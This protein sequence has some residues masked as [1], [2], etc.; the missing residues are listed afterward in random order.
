MFRARGARDI[1]W[2]KSGGLRSH[3]NT[4]LFHLQLQCVGPVPAI[5]EPR[6]PFVITDPSSVYLLN[7]TEPT[8]LTEY[9]QFEANRNRR[10]SSKDRFHRDSSRP[11]RRPC[12]IGSTSGAICCRLG[13]STPPISFLNGMCLCDLHS[14]IQVGFNGTGLLVTMAPGRLRRICCT[15]SSV[16]PSDLKSWRSQIVGRLLPWQIQEPAWGSAMPMYCV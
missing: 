13:T 16:A 14:E 5:E 2:V 1:E 15:R 11:T 4:G 12:W 9:P 8:G 10:I 7:E 3:A 6:L